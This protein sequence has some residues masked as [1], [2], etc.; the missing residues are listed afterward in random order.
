MASTPPP[1]T[2]KRG[3][4]APAP[5]GASRSPC[6][7]LNALANHGYFPRDGRN[8]HVEEVAS[9]LREI[10][11]S[12][13]F[14]TLLAN[15]IFQEMHPAAG[16]NA[17][18]QPPKPL[19]SKV[20][21]AVTNPWSLFAGFSFRRPGQVDAAGKPVLNLDQLALHNRVEHDVS[22]TRT[23]FYQGD[24]VKMQPDMVR[25]LLASSSDGGKTLTMADLAALRKR[26]I[27][28]QKE[29][30][31]E[32][33]YK[34]GQHTVACAEMALILNVLGDGE[35]VPCDYVRSLFLEERLPIKEGW[36][37]REWWTLGFVE[38]QFSVNR[39]KKLIGLTF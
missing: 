2:L 39:I 6:P 36:K 14:S 31:P 23:D 24:N 10:G 19:L 18:A 5:P 16:N 1:T 13:P 35:K 26:R 11:L 29:V 28:R 9:G 30:N 15:P 12:I 21:A 32:I 8:V 17:A 4:Y 22:L 3:E 7:A 27:E 37:R 20:A 25:D 34:D 33:L 38:L